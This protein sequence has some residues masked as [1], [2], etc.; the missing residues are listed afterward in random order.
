MVS[1]Y[2]HMVYVE[3]TLEM[4]LNKNEWMDTQNKAPEIAAHDNDVKIETTQN[5][6]MYFLTLILFY[7]KQKPI[8]RETVL[9]SLKTDLVIINILGLTYWNFLLFLAYFYNGLNFD[10]ALFLTIL[11]RS[12]FVLLVASSQAYISLNGNICQWKSIFQGGASSFPEQAA[13]GLKL[14]SGFGRADFA[15]LPLD[16]YWGESSGDDP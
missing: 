3:I 1:I 11:A 8:G 13:P 5:M 9:D 15:L 14:S 16:P 10:L 12:Y 2:V 7:Q 6:C 4:K